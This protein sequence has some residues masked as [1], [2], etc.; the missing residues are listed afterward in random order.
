[1]PF[2]R[3]D[4]CK[5]YPSIENLF[6]DLSIDLN[7]TEWIDG[8]WIETNTDTLFIEVY[9]EG[10]HQGFVVHVWNTP[11]QKNKIID[12][13]TKSKSTFI[14]KPVVAIEAWD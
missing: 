1:M 4:W 5:Q 14:Q 9:G 12:L 2:F 13:L 6:K 10:I 7:P 8:G 11:N 3:S